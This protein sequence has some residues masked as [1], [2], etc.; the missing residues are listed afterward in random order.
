[1]DFLEYLEKLLI[2]IKEINSIRPINFVLI[3]GDL[4]DRGG[5]QFKLNKDQRY[6]TFESQVITPIISAIGISKNKV[7]FI[8]GNHDVE[9]VSQ[10]DFRERGL[11][12]SNIK[13][14]NQLVKDNRKEYFDGNS[15]IKKYKDFERA[16]YNGHP[17]CEL[18]PFESFWVEDFNG[19][20]IGFVGLNSAW[21]CSTKLP[22]GKLLI[23]VDK[24][25]SFAKTFFE[26]NHTD[27]NIALLHHPI[28]CIAEV[29]RPEI[30][31]YLRNAKI[32][33]LFGGHT[34]RISVF[35]TVRNESQLFQTLARIGFTDKREEAEPYQAGFSL[36]EL[37]NSIFNPENLSIQ[38]TFYKY[39]NSS[40]GFDMDVLGGKGGKA[41]YVIS[42]KNCS[43]KFL[44]NL[45]NLHPASANGDV[46][47]EA[48]KKAKKELLSL[49]NKLTVSLIHSSFKNISEKLADNIRRTMLLDE[50]KFYN[51]GNVFNYTIRDYDDDHFELIE[52]YTFTINTDKESINFERTFVVEKLKENDK[53]DILIEKLL[54]NNEDYTAFVQTLKPEPSNDPRTVKIKKNFNIILQSKTKYDVILVTR[55]IHTH[56]LNGYWR[57]YLS[58]I[59]EGV[60]VN[61]P[62]N[63]DYEIDT[64]NFAKGMDIQKGFIPLGSDKNKEPVLF[65]PGD[66]FALII[67]KIQQPKIS[68]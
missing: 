68:T 46:I 65:M 33:L 6:E 24:Q 10:E 3:T 35:Q 47:M 14:I 21:R 63:P 29:E 52:E 64:L 58:E 27:L 59:T 16:F 50:E 11:V 53:S 30:E 60:R 20:K 38:C 66:G 17:N 54:I 23:G 1:V 28:E 15:R 49:W 61:L 8:P 18:S 5:S 34:H 36:I 12:S 48:Q 22:E 67:K 44:S 62:E 31:L 2:E 45:K 55:S 56:H 9:D 51:T 42:G 32:S 19:F 39:V 4:L 25:L 41:T 37:S 26:N 13:Y 43:D 7:L 40:L 57:R